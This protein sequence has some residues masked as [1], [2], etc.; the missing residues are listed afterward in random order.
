MGLFCQP[1]L[2]SGHLR[3]FLHDYGGY[4]FTAQLGRALA[5]RGHQVV[6][7]YS[8]TTQLMQRFS[9]HSEVENFMV[10]AISLPKPFAR[11]NYM[12]RWRDES[13][14]GRK[15]AQKVRDFRPDVVLSANA[16]IGR[17]HV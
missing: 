6:Y 3:V 8:L 2:G 15:V 4:S 10:E 13:A 11:Y 9:L 16:Q 17:A 12:R 5:G 7:S 14:H 1:V